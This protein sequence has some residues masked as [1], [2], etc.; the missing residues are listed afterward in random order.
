MKS[1]VASLLLITLFNSSASFAATPVV[2]E[3]ASGN[4]SKYSTAGH[5]KSKGVNMVLSYPR[6]WLAQEGERPNIVQ[7]FFSEH[8]KGLEGALIITKSLG[9]PSGTVISE[10]ELKELFSPEELKTMLPSGANFIQAKSTK[11]EGLPAGI[12][13][14]TTREERA[15]LIIYTQVISYIFVYNNILIQ[16]QCLVSTGTN[17]NQ[18]MLALKMD[19]FRPLFGLMANS[20][21]LPDKWK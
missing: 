14:Y 9:I 11:I 18:D 17:S 15:G 13:E 19:K 10:T 12:L 3:F 20:I 5:P 7:K 2:K 21:V 1:I 8:G 4:Q 16:F 6:S